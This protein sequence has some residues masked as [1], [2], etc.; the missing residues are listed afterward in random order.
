MD[1]T[2]LDRAEAD[3]RATFATSAVLGMLALSPDRLRSNL[4]SVVALERIVLGLA[5][6]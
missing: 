3:L 2:G 5:R 1:A 4:D 6:R